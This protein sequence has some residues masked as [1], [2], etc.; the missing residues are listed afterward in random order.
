MAELFSVETINTLYFVWLNVSWRQHLE[1]LRLKLPC[2]CN[3]LNEINVPNKT[4]I[5]I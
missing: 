3:P 1:N 4:S 2:M 5:E